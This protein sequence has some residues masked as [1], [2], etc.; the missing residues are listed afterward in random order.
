MRRLALV[1]AGG[2]CGTLA[3]YLLSAPLLAL[4]AALLPRFGHGAMPYDIL[5]INLTGALALGLL[6]GLFERGVALP[7]D[8]RLVVGTGFL[9]AYT[10]F[11]SFVYGGDK[12]LLGGALLPGMLYLLGSVALG[13]AAA[14]CGHLLAGAVA[15][16]RRLARRGLVRTRRVWRHVRSMRAPHDALLPHLLARRGQ[17]R[18]LAGGASTH[19]HA[20]VYTRRAVPTRAE[21]APHEVEEL[22]D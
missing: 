16:R 12:L 11:S 13:V 3:R 19:P 21:V 8:L 10:T 17:R 18:H 9:G 14:H 7:P 20:A 1:F 4:F 5:A 15:E 6:Y 2:F 22:A